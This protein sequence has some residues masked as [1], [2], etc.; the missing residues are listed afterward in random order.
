MDDL[1]DDVRRRGASTSGP[2]VALTGRDTYRGLLFLGTAIP[3]GTVW[4]AALIA[5]WTLT[6]AVAITP[7]VVVVVVRSGVFADLAARAES[8]TARELLAMPSY[9]ARHRGGLGAALGP[10]QRAS[11]RH[12][13]R[14]HPPRDAAAHPGWPGTPRARRQPRPAVRGVVAPACLRSAWRQHD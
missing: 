2:L 8:A 11:V 12:L 1:T 7:F 10:L 4:M 5:G 13:A 3:F 6:V 9:P 14:R